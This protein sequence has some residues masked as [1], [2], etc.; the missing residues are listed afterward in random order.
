[1]RPSSLAGE[2]AS[3]RFILD[4]KPAAGLSV[5][6][7]R[8]G[9]FWKQKPP[10]I[11][12]KTSTDGGVKVSGPESGVRLLSASYHTGETGRGDAPRGPIGGLGGP[13]HPAPSCPTAGGRRL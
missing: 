8:G 4:G 7:K 2:P 5:V 12:L 3:F 10:E 11:E 6:L 13:W 9:D 1:M